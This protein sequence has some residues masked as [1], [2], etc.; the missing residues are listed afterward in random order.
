MQNGLFCMLHQFFQ[1]LLQL[2]LFPV[3]QCV[4]KFFPRISVM[5]RVAAGTHQP[6]QVFRPARGTMAAVMAM[7]FFPVPAGMPVALFSVPAMVTM[8]AM[9][10]VRLKV[11]RVSAASHKSHESLTPSALQALHRTCIFALI[12]VFQF[13]RI[14]S[15]FTP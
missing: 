11:S 6:R 1:Q 15:A 10:F 9:L 7:P 3:C 5:E 14:H 12:T 2:Y 4:K 8:P 13:S